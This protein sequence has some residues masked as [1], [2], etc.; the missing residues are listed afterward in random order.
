RRAA[1]LDRQLVEAGA[2]LSAAEAAVGGQR[3]RAAGSMA[4][5]V[6][7]ELRALALPRAPF[8]VV[9]GDADPGD[10]VVFAFG[11]NPGEPVLPLV[12]VASGGE[13]S[14]VMLALRLVLTSSGDS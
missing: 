12:K 2:A 5:K 14:R 4:K 13:L 7:S 11:A 9:V 10:D 1:D 6:Q 8:E 3:R